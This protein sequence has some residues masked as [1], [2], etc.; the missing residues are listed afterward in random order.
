MVP[1]RIAWLRLVAIS[2]DVLL[3]IVIGCKENILAVQ[4]NG[5]GCNFKRTK[6]QKNYSQG[7]QKSLGF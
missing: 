7:E 4:L 3:Q 2:F 6:M 1:S 5:C